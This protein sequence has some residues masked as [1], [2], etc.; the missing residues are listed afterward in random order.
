[1]GLRAGYGRQGYHTEGAN[2]VKIQ[3]TGRFVSAVKV[4]VLLGANF[5]LVGL[6][7]VI[8]GVYRRLRQGPYQR[9]GRKKADEAVQNA[10]GV[11]TGG[12]HGTKVEQRFAAVG[13][14]RIEVFN[15]D[16]PN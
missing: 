6:K 15:G 8:S 14:K 2:G 5:V 12:E 7:R 3:P 1:V 4:D 9:P 10:V 13:F 11:R 16:W